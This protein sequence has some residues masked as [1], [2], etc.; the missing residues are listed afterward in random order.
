MNHFVGKK[1]QPMLDMK[2]EGLG[3]K[4]GFTQLVT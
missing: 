4:Q 1:G 2:E 3:T